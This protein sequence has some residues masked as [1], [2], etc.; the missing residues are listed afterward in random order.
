MKVFQYMAM[1]TVPVV[2]NVGDLRH[3]VR[4]G[5]AGVIVPWGNVGEL[6]RALTELLQDE[7]GRVRMSKE[8]WRLASSE[9]SWQTRAESLDRFLGETS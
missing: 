9:Y 4:D 2:S 7:V 1:R 5:E 3:Y 6:A 8:A